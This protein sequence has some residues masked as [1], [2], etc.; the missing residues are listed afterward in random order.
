MLRDELNSPKLGTDAAMT[1]TNANAMLPSLPC[2]LTAESPTKPA[3]G[4]RP[5]TNGLSERRREGGRDEA[6]A[7]R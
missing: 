5:L 6:V 7:R 3:N 4:Q 1:Q 2:L